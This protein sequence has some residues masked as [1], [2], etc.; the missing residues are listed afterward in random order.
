M[1][2]ANNG[3]DIP[4]EVSMRRILSSIFIACLC[5]LPALAQSLPV[6]SYP[7]GK[8][9]VA[10]HLF[11]TWADNYM[12]DAKRG[13]AIGEEFLFGTGAVSLAGAALTWYEGD[14]ISN[15][16]SGSPMDPDIKRNLT[17]GLGIGG[18]VFIL[19][20]LI[21]Q[22]VPI[23]DYRAIYADVFQE[24][25][26]E[27]QEAMAVSVLRYQADRGKERRITSFVVG[28][29]VP[30]LAGGIQA[31]VNLAQGNPWGKDMLTT[32]GNSSWWM[33]GS[34][35]DLFRKTPEERLYDRYLTTRDAL[36][37]TGR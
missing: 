5:S 15:N 16:L 12:A 4:L 2:I 20:G 11:S 22:S 26:P 25:D 27:V 1:E 23:K 18:G 31:G 24:R 14:A 7:Y 19:A 17:M 9:Q 35:V 6:A 29:V 28:L 37:G 30:L 13:K 34:I 3:A 36:Y 33:A 21:V 10:Y 32:M 8:P